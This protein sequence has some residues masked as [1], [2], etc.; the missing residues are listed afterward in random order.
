MKC[1]RCR[2]EMIRQKTKEHTY[3]YV[4]PKCKSKSVI[5]NAEKQNEETPKE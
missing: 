5:R 1:K 2:T 4:C 3:V